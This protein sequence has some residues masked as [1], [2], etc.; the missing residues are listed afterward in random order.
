MWKNERITTVRTLKELIV[1]TRMKIRNS[2]VLGWALAG[3][4]LGT[5]LALAY[6]ASGCSLLHLRQDWAQVVFYPGFLVGYH[7]F[8]VL[9]YSAAV[10]LACLAVGF[11]YSAIASAA[12]GL[13]KQLVYL[14]KLVGR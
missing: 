1:G 13:I 4:S 5:I 8:D 12:A 9:G 10:S 3:F 7:T 6:V 2:I 11:A 14:L